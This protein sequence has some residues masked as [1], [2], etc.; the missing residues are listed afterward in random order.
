[1]TSS[2][3]IKGRCFVKKTAV[4]L[5]KENE[6]QEHPIALSSNCFNLFDFE[7]SSKL[8]A[9]LFCL[10]LCFGNNSSSLRPKTAVFLNWSVNLIKLKM[11][12]HLIQPRESKTTDYR[13]SFA[14]TYEYGW[15][16]N[17]KKAS[18]QEYGTQ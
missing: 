15:A 10:C 5:G 14:F 13:N 9:C 4:P 18:T 7:H 11:P 8:L 3:Q 17:H 1:M 16:E 6:D 12:T 2:A